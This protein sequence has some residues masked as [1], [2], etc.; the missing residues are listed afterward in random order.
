MTTRVG[1][2]GMMVGIWLLFT[3]T[4]TFNIAEISASAAD[5]RLA[6]LVVTVAAVLLFAGAVGK[7]AQ[8]PLHVWLPDAMAGPTPVS[9]LIHAATMV[10]AGV[11]LVARSYG[12]FV[13]SPEAM[14]TVAVIGGLTALFAATVAT[15][16]TDFKAVLAYSTISQLG[17]M[18]LGLGVGGFV[19]GVFHLL[20][21]AFFKALL[22]LTAGSVSHATGTLEIHEMGGLRR[23]MR[24]T[25]WT[26][27][28]GALAL[29]GI[30]PLAGFWSKDEILVAAY[31]SGHPVLFWMAVGAAFLTAYYM[32]R[33][34]CL[35][36]LGRPR[37]VHRFEHAH[38]APRVM[39]GPLVVLASLAAL[40]GL[41]GSPVAGCWLG[42]FLDFSRSV[43]GLAAAGH[44]AA[45][46]AGHTAGAAQAAAHAAHTAHAAGPVLP[47]A[48][49]AALLGIAAGYVLYGTRLIDRAVLIRAFRPV[50]TLLKSRYYLDEVYGSLL[51][52]PAVR[53]AELCGVF[54]LR[55]IDGAVNGVA[56]AAVEASRAARRFDDVVID[57]AVEGVAAAAV[58]ASR[59]AGQFDDV[60]IDGAVN[61]VA[62]GAVAGGRT[63]RRVHTGQVQG[64]MAAIYAGAALALAALVWMLL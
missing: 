34:T 38:E 31:G 53:L 52:R 18:M 4:G 64:Y 59:A 51:V 1:D 7:S 60:V 33:L 28:I 35:V 15:V 36:F 25:F 56:A 63:L 44:A 21:H 45:H 27:L 14:L 48:L 29:A 57:G 40:A 47:V 46:A 8:F 39:A 17:Y 55:V 16:M 26:F 41:P 23:K 19:A 6:P 32:T 5:G 13:H 12:I 9:A 58:E 24:L 30:P 11:Y 22:F 43:P 61:G 20:T 54:D 10:A 37:D 49:G 42:R 50:Y 2:V 3:H 62:A